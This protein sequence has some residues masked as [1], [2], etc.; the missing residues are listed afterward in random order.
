M[1]N[2]WG[3]MNIWQ[4]CSKPREKKK[5]G[6]YKVGQLARW[7]GKADGVFWNTL[8]QFY[9]RGLLGLPSFTGLTV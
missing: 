8:E 5:H 7:P 6:Q 3:N 4:Y 2:V 9:P 1:A